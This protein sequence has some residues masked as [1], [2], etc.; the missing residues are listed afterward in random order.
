MATVGVALVGYGFGNRAFHG[1]LIRETEGLEIR[2][3]LST[4]P[5]RQQQAHQ[6]F[7]GVRIYDDYDALLAD[8]HIDLVVISTPHSTH[9]P[10]TIQACRRG[11]HVVVD[12]IMALNVAEAE[13]MVKAAEQASV[14]LSVF[15]N[16]RWDSDFLTVKAVLQQGL[17]GEPYVIESSVVGYRKP[18]A[19]GS[20]LPWRMQARYGGGAV[21]DW[22][23]HLLDQAIQLFGS[24]IRSVYADFQYRWPGIDVESA[25][26]CWVRFAE[27]V[28]F[29][30]EVGSIS[31]I[32]RPRW[33]VRGSQGA[34]VIQGLD[35]Q[36]AELKR[37]V[38]ISGS[39]Q[40][41]IAYESCHFESD[42]P[43]AKLQI[44]PGDYLAY[45]R[46]IAAA[47][48]HGAPLAVTPESVLD[49]LRL[50]ESIVASAAS[51]TVMNLP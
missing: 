26:M 33:Y 18:P 45:Y 20:H 42:I 36:E 41:C 46:N 29:R 14:L 9:A 44:V 7:P 43:E 25:A 23:A 1:P 2:A 40:A 32:D 12:K 5:D 3:V 17:L 39:D 19:A 51:G 37:N 6:H 47:L 50:L 16:R 48:L 15:H 34:L 8:K 10:L 35:P 30:M 11:K 22:G 13:S 38:V 31:K 49:S 21:R 24:N 4:N 27:G 28:R